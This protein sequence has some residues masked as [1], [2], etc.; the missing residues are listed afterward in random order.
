MSSAYNLERLTDAQETQEA[1]DVR[2]NHVDVGSCLKG[3]PAAPN[4]ASYTDEKLR[5]IIYCAKSP[6]AEAHCPA[7]TSL[8]VTLPSPHPQ[9]GPPLCCI[10]LVCMVP[11]WQLCTKHLLVSDHILRDR[12]LGMT[13]RLANS[14]RSLSSS[15]RE[16]VH[17]PTSQSY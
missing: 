16:I 3:F 1:H 17:G 2:S 14:V 8:H 6:R 4:S 12:S 13:S 7:L 10:R 15:T 11:K 9:S 5:E